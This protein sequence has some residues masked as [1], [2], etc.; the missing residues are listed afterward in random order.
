METKTILL[1]GE[2]FEVRQPYS[3]G[4]I[5]TAIEARQLNQVRAEGVANNMRKRVQE[6]KAAGKLDEARAQFLS[7]DAEYEFSLPGRSTPID[8]VE[9]EATKLA[10]DWLRDQLSKKGLKMNEVHPDYAK[11]PEDEGKA[12]TKERYE[13]AIEKASMSETILEIARE[14]VAQMERAAKSSGISV[15]V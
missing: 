12:K 6:A 8:P 13:A 7:Y 9:R 15:E 5:C 1:D 3:E 11:L 10:K 14:R 4:H 2:K